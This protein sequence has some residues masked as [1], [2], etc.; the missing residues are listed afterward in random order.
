MA[1]Q[2]YEKIGGGSYGIY[3]PKKKESFLEVVFG[4]LGFVFIVGIIGLIFG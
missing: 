4:F 3:R 1:K 2:E